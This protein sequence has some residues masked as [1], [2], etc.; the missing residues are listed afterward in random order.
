MYPVEPNAVNCCDFKPFSVLQAEKAKNEKQKGS[1]VDRQHGRNGRKSIKGKRQHC[2]RQK[3]R[4]ST[5]VE[6]QKGQQGRKGST[7]SL[8]LT[9]L[10]TGLP[11]S[12]LSTCPLSHNRGDLAPICPRPLCLQSTTT[13]PFSANNQHHRSAFQL[14]LAIV[15]AQLAKRCT[16]NYEFGSEA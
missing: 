8:S 10:T 9:M 13:L 4:K 11:A 2:V 16:C 1:K 7:L 14:P 15:Y 6:R 3:G 12:K 5:K